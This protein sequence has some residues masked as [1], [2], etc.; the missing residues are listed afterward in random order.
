MLVKDYVAALLEF[1]KNVNKLYMT[2]KPVE[3]NGKLH[4]KDYPEFTP[5]LTPQKMFELGSFGGTYW[6]PIKS[7][8]FKTI[9]RNK[10]EKYPKSWWKDVPENWLTTHMDKY[11]EKI[12]KYGVRVGTSLEFWEEKGWIEKTHPY[13]WVQWYCDFYTGKRSHDDERQIKRWKRLA[14]PN[15]RFRKWLVTMILKKKGEWNDYEISPKMRQTLQ[16]WG[17]VLTKSNFNKEVSSRK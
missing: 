6:R 17:Y 10:H 8:F 16:H 13:G 5:N 4:F 9:L 2:L 7:T 3:K 14:G 12:N 1:Q 15:G 11:D